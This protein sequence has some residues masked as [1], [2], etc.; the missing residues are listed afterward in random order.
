MLG[1][2]LKQLRNSAGLTQKEL[3]NKM[4][5]SSSAVSM[6]EADRRDPDTETLVKFSKVFNVTTDYLLGETS[7]KPLTQEHL[8]TINDAVNTHLGED[9]SIMFKDINNW[10]EEKIKKLKTFI[11]LIDEGKI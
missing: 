8:T 2:R 5:I 7:N 3:A 4:N 11:E 9:I 6:Y 10:D 1:K